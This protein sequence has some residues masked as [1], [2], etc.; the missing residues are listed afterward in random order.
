MQQIMTLEEVT[1]GPIDDAVFDLPPEI[2]ALREQP[3]GS[4]GE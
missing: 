1:F 3:A 2:A 4:S